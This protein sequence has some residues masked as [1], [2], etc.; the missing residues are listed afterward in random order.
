VTQGLATRIRYRLGRLF[1]TRAATPLVP[2]SLNL[3]PVPIRS[4]A[5][6]ETVAMQQAWTLLE[7]RRGSRRFL[8]RADIDPGDFKPIL[9]TM[10]LIEVHYEPLRF[11]I[12]LA[13][14]G[15]RDTLGFEATGL[16]LH[17]W[18]S[19]F[20]KTVLELAW[21][22]SVTERRAGRARRHA[23]IEGVTLQYEAVTI[24]LAGDD[25]TIDMLLAMSAPWR[26]D[27]PPKPLDP[28]LD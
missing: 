21:T 9:S 20:Q 26:A 23:I 14:T 6:L 1:G 10:G 16:W 28:L 8:S 27:T 12:R 5:D 22:T 25:E 11:R 15:W 17:D 2:D 4:V 19:A 7:A 18:P 3:P 13:G 24:P